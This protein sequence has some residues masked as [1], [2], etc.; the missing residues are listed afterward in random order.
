M[1]DI[2]GKYGSELKKYGPKVLPLEE[3]FENK[4]IPEP[5]SGCWLWTCC[6]AHYG[7]GILYF[8]RG[9]ILAH[10][11]SYTRFIGP[12]PEGHFVCHKCD[13]PS[14]VNPDH[15][16]AGTPQDNVDDKVRKNRHL[17]GEDH[18]GAVLSNKDVISIFLSSKTYLDL[19][20]EFHVSQSSIG[21]IKT[22]DGW[23]P[24][25]H[26]LTKPHRLLGSS[27]ITNTEVL[28][29]YRSPENN[30][31]LSAKYGVSNS[32]IWQLKNGKTWSSITGHV[33]DGK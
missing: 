17:P 15:L 28:E 29:I 21:R 4:Y 11:Y 30:T 9:R 26:D 14:C 5:N 12:I 23:G 1:T 25:T 20:K 10:R 24:V 18:P 16:F 31:H 8:P 33:E 32:T 22:G 19:A 13:V 27:K 3:K 6:V 2:I 7:Y